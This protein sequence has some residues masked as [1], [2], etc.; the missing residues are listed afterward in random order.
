VINPP[1]PSVQGALDFLRVSPL[2]LDS[3]ERLSRLLRWA[4]LSPKML[5]YPPV[6]GRVPDDFAEALSA[7][8]GRTANHEWKLLKPIAEHEIKRIGIDHLAEQAITD[9]NRLVKE[10]EDTEHS[11]RKVRGNRREMAE[12]NRRKRSLLERI[13][14][15]EQRANMLNAFKQRLEDARL[16]LN[17][18]AICPVCGGS[19]KLQS[20]SDD[21]FLGECGNNGCEARWELRPTTAGT[22][23][24]ILEPGEARE[25]GLPPDYRPEAVDDL[26]GCDILAVPYCDDQGRTG[27]MTPRLV[28]Q[29]GVN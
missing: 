12:L 2:A 6:L 11:M 13:N 21:C 5:E 19:G 25:S 18:L 22:R 17:E 14:E 15:T 20:R 28:S 26:L 4:L 27:W 3:V 1:F 16:L 24:P 8:S 9:F 23:T 7:Y 10:R 29:S